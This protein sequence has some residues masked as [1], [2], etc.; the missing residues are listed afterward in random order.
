[1]ARDGRLP[2]GQ[3]GDL[4][5]LRGGSER[6]AQ[7]RRRGR[8]RLCGRLPRRRRRDSEVLAGGQVP[9]RLG[10]R[11]RAT[12]GAGHSRRLPLCVQCLREERESALPLQTL[13]REGWRLR[14]GGIV[15]A[16]HARLW[17]GWPTL[18]R[19]PR[20]RRDRRVRRVGREARAQGRLSISCASAR[21]HVAGL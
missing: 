9:G 19:Q 8:N 11:A 20:Q 15:R 18:H 3:E 14:D 12:R 16:A 17:R 1:M 10:V 2:V 7:H 5:R 4:A 13:R 6:S 21:R